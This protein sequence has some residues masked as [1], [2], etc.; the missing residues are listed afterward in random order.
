MRIFF[1]V[2][3]NFY[4][5]FEGG[6][7]L[8]LY[9][10]EKATNVKNNFIFPV[11]ISAFPFLRSVRKKDEKM[12]NWED[13]GGGNNDGDDVDLSSFKESNKKRENI[14]LLLIVER[15]VLF[16]FFKAALL[17]IFAHIGQLSV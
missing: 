5:Y 16:L 2:V 1:V 6:Q 3:V 8:C 9:V 13:R 14:F 17:V 4:F 12:R 11:F 15:F 7:F 10:F